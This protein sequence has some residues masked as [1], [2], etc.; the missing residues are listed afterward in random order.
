VPVRA[1]SR[2]LVLA[3]GAAE[4]QHGQSRS[5]A[6]RQPSVQPSR[7]ARAVQVHHRGDAVW[8]GLTPGRPARYA[9]ADPG[10][11]M[12]WLQVGM[13]SLPGWGG[14]WERR[15]RLGSDG[16]DIALKSVTIYLT[17]APACKRSCKSHGTPPAPLSPVRLLT[18]GC[19]TPGGPGRTPRE[20]VR[21]P[22][23]P[24]SHCR[25]RGSR[26]LRTRDKG[27]FPLDQPC[28]VYIWA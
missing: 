1:V 6:A 23:P 17:P 11:P 26:P 8:P 3:G 7:Q 16:S 10:R 22:P 13:V 25:G 14:P 19:G 15:E 21:A 28:L 20:G 27:G 12:V 24:R 4:M 2:A 18:G 5:L 9:R